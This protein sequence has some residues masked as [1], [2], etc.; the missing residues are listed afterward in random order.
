M[1]STKIKFKQILSNRNTVMIL[2]AL[3]GV[4]VLFVAYNIRVNQAVE[5][6]RV[7]VASQTIQPRTRITDDMIEYKSVAKNAIDPETVIVDVAKLIN[8]YSRVNTV[9]PKGSMFY[10]AAVVSA[11]ERPDSYVDQ[12]EDGETLFSLNVDINDTYGNSLLPGSFIDVYIETASAEN[13]VLT[14]KFIRNIKLLAVKDSKGDNVFENS[15]VK[16]VPATIIF[17]LP[18]EMHRLLSAAI[19]VGYLSGQD[20][21]TIKPIPIKVDEEEAEDLKPT[22]ANEATETYIRERMEELPEDF[23]V[24]P[25]IMPNNKEVNEEE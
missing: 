19:Y 2:A 15:D 10:T 6:V 11:E 21:V 7:P 20:A 1:N 25:I 9:I 5:P 4:I 3:A 23:D 8:Y 18:N 13:K 24:N 12:L 14:G 22:L 17:A 16:R